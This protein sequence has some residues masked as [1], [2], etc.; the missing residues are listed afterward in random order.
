[1]PFVKIHCTIL[2]SSIWS[3]PHTTRIVWLTLLSMANQ[4]GVVEASVDGLA[5]RAVVTIDEC[6]TAL[7]SFLGPDPFSR[8]GTSGER[9]E[10]VPGG[11]FIINHGQHRDHR[12]EAQIQTAERVRRHREKQKGAV[13]GT[14]VTDTN[15]ASVSVSESRSVQRPSEVPEDLWLSWKKVRRTKRLA[16]TPEAFVKLE[17]EAKKAGLTILAAIQLCVERSWGSLQAEWLK[18]GSSHGKPLKPP[19]HPRNMPI[20]ASAN[21]ICEDCLRFRAKKA[22]VAT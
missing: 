4:H 2:D 20:G 22:A 17:G 1:M 3:L 8:D 15:G 11:W 14:E 19:E 5:R 12:T 21:C 6:Q 10:V 7:K 16:L 13:T 18:A 9:I